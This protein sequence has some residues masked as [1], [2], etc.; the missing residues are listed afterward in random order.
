MIV[1]DCYLG[2]RS[3]KSA[4]E[5]GVMENAIPKGG[6]ANGV[7]GFALGFAAIGTGEGRLMSDRQSLGYIVS[8][9]LL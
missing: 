6:F 3:H 7:G 5:F 8:Y 1:E 4:N 2:R 9:T